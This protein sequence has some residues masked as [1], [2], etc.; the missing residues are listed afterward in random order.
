M[1]PR[2]R[3]PLTREPSA[4][5]SPPPH[6]KPACRGRNTGRPSA[7]R[8]T[9]DNSVLCPETLSCLS[10]S[11]LVAGCPDPGP[12]PSTQCPRQPLLHPSRQP[13]SSLL[14]CLVR[15]AR[16]QAD[17]EPPPLGCGRPRQRA[18]EFG[19]RPL[20]KRSVAA[21]WPTAKSFPVT[22]SEKSV[23]LQMFFPHVLPLLHG[24]PVSRPHPPAFTAG[25][26][27]VVPSE[28]SS[29]APPC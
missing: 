22:Q 13:L 19:G 18:A 16:K 10:R 1:P 21:W 15:R 8:C 23:G 3:I 25:G 20:W 7:A 12:P 9:K 6:R 2:C 24:G 27:S 11:L 4:H 14:L 28:D 26:Q 17:T 29:H 5:G